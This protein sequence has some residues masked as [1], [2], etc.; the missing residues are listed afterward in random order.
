MRR[1]MPWNSEQFV[2]EVG[3]QDAFTTAVIDTG[4]Q[5]T[6]IDSVMAQKLG[7]TIEAAQHDSH[8]TYIG[9]GG[10]LKNYKGVVKGPITLRFSAQ[11]CFTFPEIRVF[12]HTYPL[13]LIGA[14]ILK[15]GQPR[16]RVPGFPICVFR[17]I[18]GEYN[19]DGDLKALMYFDVGAE[20]HG[21]ALLWCSQ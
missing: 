15:L 4:C 11:V 16:A 21:I 19:S 20:R 12:E 14:D 10:A 9:C 13:F 2:V 18:S 17:G 8:G 5:R 3:L 1:V 6:V 7:L